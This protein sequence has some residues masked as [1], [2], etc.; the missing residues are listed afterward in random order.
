MSVSN[1]C[2]KYW[3]KSDYTLDDWNPVFR[4]EHCWLCNSHKVAYTIT[5][6]QW[7]HLNNDYVNRNFLLNT[8]Q[9]CPQAP[10]W[11]KNWML[12]YPV[13]KTWSEKRHADYIVIKILVPFEVTIWFVESMLVVCVHGNYQYST[14]WNPNSHT[15]NYLI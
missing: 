14:K 5:H 2:P 8:V 12:H 15:M 9:P 4:Y 11:C 3:F 6:Q 13:F 10:K 7:M 1:D